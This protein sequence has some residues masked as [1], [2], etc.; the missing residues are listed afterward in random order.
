MNIH[1]MDDIIKHFGCLFYIENPR[2]MLRK[3]PFMKGIDRTTVC[4]CRY[5]D[6]RMKPTDSF[7]NNIRSLFVPDGWNPRQMCHNSNP[8][9]H[10]DRAPRGSKTGTQ[11]L[12][13]AHERSKMPD[14]LCDEIIIAT[15]HRLRHLI[16]SL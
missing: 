16:K 9:C 8:K 14:Q 6:H 2:G 13:N 3:M 1:V 5:G 15:E 11:G 12:K 7:S 4:F 10:H